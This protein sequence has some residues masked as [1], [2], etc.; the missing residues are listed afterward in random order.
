MTDQYYFKNRQNCWAV[1]NVLLLRAG[2]TVQ[3][4]EREL[5]GLHTSGAALGA[6]E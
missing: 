6:E 2:T 3:F 1:L 4:K 5:P